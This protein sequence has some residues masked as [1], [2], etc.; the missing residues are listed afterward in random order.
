MLP[1]S[2]LGNEYL[3]LKETTAVDFF[4][5]AVG[6]IYLQEEISPIRTIS[7]R[8]RLATFDQDAPQDAGEDHKEDAEATRMCHDSFAT[9]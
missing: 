4:C 9:R 8:N 1:G 6:T 5:D 3:L 2:A 7:S